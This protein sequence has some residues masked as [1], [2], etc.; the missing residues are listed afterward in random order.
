MADSV[1]IS[2]N[3]TSTQ[4]EF[5]K[6]LDDYEIEIFHMAKIEK[7]LNHKFSNLNEILENLVYKRL[8]SRIE[9]GKFCKATFRNEYV[10]GTFVVRKGAIAYWSALNTLGLTEQFPNTVFVQSTYQKSDKTIFGVKYKFIKIP[11]T[12]RKGIIKEGYGNYSFY[13]TD[14]EKTIVDCFDLPQYSGGYAELIRA[15]AKSQLSA[16]KLIDYS[17][18][19]NNIA[20]I[21][22]M[23]F[24]AGL[25]EKKRLKSFI[26]FARDQVRDAYNPFD[27]FG[28]ASGKFNSKW[29]LRMNISEE[30]L[31]NIAQNQH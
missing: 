4:M 30:E 10:I 15:F 12:K 31:L 24:L 25:Y 16:D 7:I 21:K 19:V 29:R 27:P 20:A 5:L 8:L 9:R 13:M 28:N 18:T 23:G 2:S 14:L 26:R 11:E 22:R 17:K 6:L 3:L 1:Y